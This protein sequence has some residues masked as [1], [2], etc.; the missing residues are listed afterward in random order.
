MSVI[1]FLSLK[2]WKLTEEGTHLSFLNRS[3]KLVSQSGPVEQPLD[4]P[5]HLLGPI[6]EWTADYKRRNDNDLQEWTHLGSHVF[7]LR[8]KLVRSQLQ[9]LRNVEENLAAVETTPLF[10]SRLGFLGHLDRVPDVFTVGLAHLCL[11][12]IQPLQP[13]LL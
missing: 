12:N 2:S 1:F 7:E 9:V 10:P 5:S 4:G 8:R 6:L 3:T 11:R 13:A